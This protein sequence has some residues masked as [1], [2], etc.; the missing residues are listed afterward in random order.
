[1][2]TLQYTP[3]DLSIKAT[4]HF[5][6]LYILPLNVGEP[7]KTCSACNYLQCIFYCL[8]ICQPHGVSYALPAV[9][10][11]L[12]GYLWVSI[13]WVSILAWMEGHF[14]LSV[15]LNFSFKCVTA[16]R[17]KTSVI[18]Q[19]LQFNSIQY[20]LFIISIT[21]HEYHSKINKYYQ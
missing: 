21:I 8:Y 20:I 12:M 10:L 9:L 1:M 19:G 13:R 3:Q 17:T 11:L 5:F 6:F 7:C 2:F 16:S 15:I 14:Y 4:S 18:M